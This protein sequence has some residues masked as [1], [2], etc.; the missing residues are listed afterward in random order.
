[1]YSFSHEDF[2]VASLQLKDDYRATCSR[3]EEVW[4]IMCDLSSELTARADFQVALAKGFDCPGLL[5]VPPMSGA[6]F[7][8][9]SSAAAQPGTTFVLRN[10]A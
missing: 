4:K 9:A 7:I 6:F 5:A 3:L 2:V 1:M 10:K 8:G